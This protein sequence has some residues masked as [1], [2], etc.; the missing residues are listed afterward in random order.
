MSVCM[1]MCIECDEADPTVWNVCIICMFCVCVFVCICMYMFVLSAIKRIRL[2]GTYV[3]CVRRV[4]VYA[5][6]YIM[7]VCV[8]VYVCLY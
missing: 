8:C 6:M 2:S 7:Y 1:C 5:C 4:C 3:L